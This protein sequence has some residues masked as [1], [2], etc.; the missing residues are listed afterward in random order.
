[1]ND[2]YI[3]KN[4][5]TVP[6]QIE[7]MF[8]THG[9]YILENRRLDFLTK[10][11]IITDSSTSTI[12]QTGTSVSNA[13]TG[14][15][16]GRAVVGGVLAGG[17]GAVIGGLSGK[18]ET[19]INTISSEIV[20]T[21]LTAELIFEDGSLMYVLLK[22]IESFQ[23][24]LGFANQPSMN[25]EQLEIEE[26]NASKQ[27]G[28][29]KMEAINSKFDLQINLAYQQALLSIGYPKNSNKEGIEESYY[30]VCKSTFNIYNSMEEKAKNISYDEF[31]N[32]YS[33][34][35]RQKYISTANAVTK[36]AKYFKVVI[37]SLIV[38]SLFVLN[39]VTS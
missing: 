13:K 9:P 39:V 11:Q 30:K 8:G 29:D 23:W 21:A 2:I 20:D 32:Q 25:D 16:L 1:M 18:R 26:E 33:N 3:F 10:V 37:V 5:E 22:S 19:Q 24:L 15:M 38:L 7:R 27:L 12:N 31:C 36:E 35:F 4:G 14:S 17:T 6:A 34:I 28:I